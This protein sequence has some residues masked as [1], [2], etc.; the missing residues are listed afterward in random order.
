MDPIASGLVCQSLYLFNTSLKFTA[1]TIRVW[2]FFLG[3]HRG[4]FPV[5][6]Y[7]FLHGCMR[8]LYRV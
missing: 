5:V 1:I 8:A 2:E 4:P 7:L 6:V 3:K